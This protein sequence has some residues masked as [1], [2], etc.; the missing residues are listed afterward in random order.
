[1]KT[2]AII[3]NDL[4]GNGA[5][6][7]MITL[8]DELISQGHQCHIVCF[9]SVHELPS[10]NMLT[11]HVFPM[12]YWRWIPRKWRAKLL[13][14]ILDRF[15]TRCIGSVPDLVLSN[16]LPADRIMS[17]SHLP[18]THLIV[19]NTISKEFTDS[20]SNGKPSDIDQVINI[21]KKKPVICVS[22]GVLLDLK[23]LLPDHTQV[24]HIYNPV[25]VDFIQSSANKP[26]P[27]DFSSPYLIH[28]GKFKSAK[29]HDRLIRAYAQSNSPLKLVLVGQG[30]LMQQTESLVQALNIK[31]RVIF[32]GFHANPYPIIAGAT[33]M[34]LSSDY[35]G[36]AM[37]ILEAL[38][39]DV[40]VISTDCPSGPGEIL[41]KNNLVATDNETELAKKIYDV[42]TTPD[43][44]KITMPEK[45]TS[46]V[47]TRQ[48]LGLINE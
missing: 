12:K 20:S 7:V 45:F 14:Q 34:V 44:F 41:P 19:H 5:E 46:Q 24:R 8:A 26:N 30:P 23:R 13:T 4:K 21:Y 42:S 17:G 32:A 36:L 9:K 29:R 16:L 39:L 2:I 1:M 31:H 22:Q 11:T 10:R 43:L 33:A 27:I 6:R 47:I 15:I 35:E 48:Y 38:V 25:D 40:P 28:V 37:V 18:N 3:I